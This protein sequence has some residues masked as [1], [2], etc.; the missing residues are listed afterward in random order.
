MTP[1]HSVPETYGF[2]G[3][4]RAEFPSQVI[5]D[6]TELCNLACVHCPHPEFK[7]SDRYAGRCLD[8]ELNT[9]AVDEVR[10]D[11]RGI[12]Q[13]LRYTGEG[14]PLLH[15]KL[16][17]LLEYAV[18][19][20]GTTVTLTTNGTLLD[21]RRC[22]RLVATGV[23]LVDVSIDA[24]TP[25][26][27]ASIRVKGKLE[28]TRANVLSLLSINAREGGKTRIVVSYVEQEGNRDETGQFED[29]WRSHGAQYVVVRRLHSNAGALTVISNGLRTRQVEDR[30]PCLFPWERISLT[31]RG[32]LAFCPQD[33]VG[34]SVIAEDFRTTTI[35]EVWQGE[36]YLRLR[37]AHLDNEWS[38]HRFCGNCP[39]W[40]HTRWPLQEGRSYADMVAEQVAPSAP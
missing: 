15:P 35:R 33:W 2:A 23:H 28:R 19:H 34:G 4:L 27:Y 36:A 12:T 37:Q 20:S 24:F 8:P 11:G 17:D 39:D 38:Q 40:Q 13:Y 6:V 25:E 10:Q 22:E 14:E 32:E 3:R 5:M 21:E 29:F 18:R 26:T 1:S 31:P 9:K 7:K 16:F 30:R